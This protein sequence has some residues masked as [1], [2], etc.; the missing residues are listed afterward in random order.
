MSK[1]L[2]CEPIT[3][4]GFRRGSYKCVCKTGYYF[5]NITADNRFFN[6]TDLEEEYSKILTVRSNFLSF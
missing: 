5:P 3:G 1:S 4:L 2:Q 6:G